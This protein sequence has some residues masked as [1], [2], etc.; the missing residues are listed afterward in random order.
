MVEQKELYRVISKKTFY[1]ELIVAYDPRHAYL[2]RFKYFFH[3][4]IDTVISHL[5]GTLDKAVHQ[6][7]FGF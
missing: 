2:D 7:Q 6:N 4:K 5:I 1:I 3:K